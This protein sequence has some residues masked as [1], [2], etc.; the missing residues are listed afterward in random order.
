M[1]NTRDLLTDAAE[2]GI[3]YLQ[4]LDARAVVPD[5][6]AVA[7]LDAFDK[8]LPDAGSDGKGASFTRLPHA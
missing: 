7:A 2:R 8:A 1:Q 4:S 6:A 3:R 5:P